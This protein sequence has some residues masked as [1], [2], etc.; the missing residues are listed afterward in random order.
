MTYK[1]PKVLREEAA[2]L[3][4]AAAEAL[5]RGTGAYSRV[6]HA[7]LHRATA[8]QIRELAIAAPGTQAEP[9]TTTPPY[10]RNLP[11][12]WKRALDMIEDAAA[13]CDGSAAYFDQNVSD[14]YDREQGVRSLRYIAGEIRCLTVR[15]VT[16]PTSMPSGC[17]RPAEPAEGL[18]E[19]SGTSP[20]QARIDDLAY[21]LWSVHPSQIKDG[22]PR[23]AFKGRG[24]K[25][26]NHY[27]DAI[28]K[29]FA[30]IARENAGLRAEVERLGGLPPAL[31]TA[32]SAGEAEDGEPGRDF[33]A[34]IALRHRGDDVEAYVM[35]AS[36]DCVRCEILIN[37]DALSENGDTLTWS[38]GRPPGVYRVRM[39]PRMRGEDDFELN[40]SAVTP[41]FELDPGPFRTSAEQ[42]QDLK[43]ALAAQATA[44][45]GLNDRIRANLEAGPRFS[46]RKATITD[47]RYTVRFDPLLRGSEATSPTKA[48]A[49]SAFSV[50]AQGSESKPEAH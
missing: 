45:P 46:G 15:P 11:P 37:G 21:R 27:A 42:V 7:A 9:V 18:V 50:I 39:N 26:A 6:Q 29:L 4:E 16:A 31:P 19:P 34:V 30:D 25:R 14:H 44:Q 32:A 43:A 5:A 33:W 17:D 28:A 23:E 47:I 2:L 1:S 48:L 20:I 8:V 41:L 36:P 10:S 12:G 22:P 13:L 49:R 40:I 35:Q 3:C 38:A 24:G